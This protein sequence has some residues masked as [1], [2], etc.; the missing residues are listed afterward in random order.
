MGEKGSGN[1]HVNGFRR[2]QPAKLSYRRPTTN[3]KKS[4]S[5]DQ[6]RFWRSIL[7]VHYLQ[8]KVSKLF[9]LWD[10]G[11]LFLLDLILGTE[12]CFR[13]PIAGDITISDKFEE[14][15]IYV[16]PQLNVFTALWLN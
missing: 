2:L 3:N 10:K 9:F 4:T 15:Q 7:A 16:A 11:I 13:K 1:T 14:N 8:R 6:T 12:Y 5:P